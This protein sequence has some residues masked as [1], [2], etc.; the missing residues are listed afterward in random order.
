MTEPEKT[1]PGKPEPSS[2]PSLPPEARVDRGFLGAAVR[3]CAKNPFVGIAIVALGLVD[4]SMRASEL[5]RDVFPDL[6]TPVFNVIVQAP[7]MGTE[8]IERRVVMPIERAMSG[9]PDLR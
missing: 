8:E 1:E 3:W 7:A 6:T 5:P 2:L 9:L 4:V